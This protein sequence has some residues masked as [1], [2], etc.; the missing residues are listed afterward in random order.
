MKKII[1]AIHNPKLNEELKKENNFKIIGKDLQYKE[2]IIELLEKNRK[3]DLIII[4]EN[5]LGEISFEKLFEKINLI[6]EK[7]KIIFIL[8]KEN[9]E[10]KKILLK[11]NINEIYYNK[12]I[13]LNK[14]IKIINKKENNVKDRTIEKEKSVSIKSGFEEKNLIAKN[15]KKDNKASKTVNE[16][17]IMLNKIITFSGNA[18]SGK[19]TLALI[20]S[21]CLSNQNYRVLLVD[22]DFEKHDLSIILK[23]DLKREKE[24]KIFFKRNLQKEKNGKSRKTKDKIKDGLNYN[25][26]KNENILKIRNEKNKKLKIKNKNIKNKISKLEIKNDKLKIKNNKLNLKNEKIKNKINNLDLKN[27]KN[28]INRKI[29][30][31]NFKNL[32][33]KKFN[34]KNKIYI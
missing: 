31:Y 16:T 18:K 14:L 4:S 22:G 1:T 30:I 6:N 2:A 11:N 23:N 29:K 13:N 5:L 3:I 33:I 27:K 24:E 8:E 21:Q 26:F 19:T 32:K 25:N 20:I 10:L 34:S 9:E 7:I 12:K 17:N 28:K 15:E